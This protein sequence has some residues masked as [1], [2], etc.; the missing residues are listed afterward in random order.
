MDL[1]LIIGLL[2]E[3]TARS[4]LKTFHVRYCLLLCLRYILGLD[5]I[6]LV[7]K[8]GYNRWVV[9]E[10]NFILRSYLLGNSYRLK[11]VSRRSFKINFKNALHDDELN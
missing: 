10:L 2:P 4:C 9:F 1:I 8:L 7:E 6:N 3:V 11:L 5:Y